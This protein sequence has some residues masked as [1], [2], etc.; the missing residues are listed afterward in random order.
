M[1]IIGLPTKAQKP[2]IGQLR[3]GDKKP[4][5]SQPGKNLSYFRFVSD[6]PDIEAA[7]LAAYGPE[8]RQI[9][10]ILPYDTIAENFEAWKELHTAGALQH[11]CDGK[12]CV[13]WLKADKLT[14]EADPD[15]SQQKP[16][17]GGCKYTGKVNLIIPELGRN[18]VVVAI[19]GGFWDVWSLQGSFL[20][21][22]ESKFRATL[23]GLPVILRRVHRE[24]SKPINGKKSRVKEWLLQIE[25][26]PMFVQALLQAEQ[27]AALTGIVQERLQLNAAPVQPIEIPEDLDSIEY[28]IEEDD[29]EIENGEIVEEIHEAEPVEAGPVSDARSRV[30]EARAKLIALVKSEDL[31]N[32]KVAVLCRG[33]FEINQVTEED[34]PKVEKMLSNFLALGDRAHEAMAGKGARK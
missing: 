9:N 5:A 31:V 19:T 27:K 21:L 2:R 1:P 7:F 4:N 3:K 32:Q 23:K 12:F 14:Y 10:A 24:I 8:P 20:D 29:A 25:A 6:D 33:I 18:G 16:C 26:H 28:E 15:M 34:L 17:P 13:L 11:R 22:D 30:R